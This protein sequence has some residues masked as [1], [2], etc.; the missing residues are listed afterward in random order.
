MKFLGVLIT[1]IIISGCSMFKT[2]S[3]DEVKQEEF[4]KGCFVSMNMTFEE[5]IPL[6]KLLDGCLKLERSFRQLEKERESSNDSGEVRERIRIEPR[7]ISSGRE[8]K[9]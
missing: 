3:L 2:K 5:A 8:I 6:E 4:V 7:G 1:A 9:I